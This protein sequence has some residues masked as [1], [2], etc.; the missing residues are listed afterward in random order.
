LYVLIFKLEVN[1]Y[2]LSYFIALG[3]I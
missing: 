3:R 2:V 1:L